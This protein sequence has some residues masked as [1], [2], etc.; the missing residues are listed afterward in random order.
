MLILYAESLLNK[1]YLKTGTEVTCARAHHA[2]KE[3][4]H[5]REIKITKNNPT[6]DTLMRLTASRQCGQSQVLDNRD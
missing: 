1:L 6:R 3:W 5:S 2:E 4:D